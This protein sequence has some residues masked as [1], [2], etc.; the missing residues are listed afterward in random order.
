MD[1]GITLEQLSLYLILFADDMVIISRT[2]EGLQLSLD[3]LQCYCE[4]WNLSVN[5][6][7][8]KIMVFRKDG[9]LSYNEHW[10]YNG[11]ELEIVN[12]FNYLGLVF[13]PGGSFMQATKTLSGKALRA[14]CSL[15][16]ITRNMEVPLNIMLN[17]FDSFV[18]SILCYASEIWG[19]MS[20]EMIERVQRKFCKWMLNV[21][22][23]TNNLAILS[24]LG[25]LPLCIERKV[26]IVKYWFKLFSNDNGNII[27]RVVYNQLV[28]DID[29]GITNWAYKVKR[30]LESSRFPEVWMFPGSVDTKTFI[31]V[32]RKRLID[33]H[34]SNWREEMEA[35]SS[36]SLFRHFKQTYELAPYLT[37]VLNRTYR[38]I[39]AKLRLS[40]HPLL[41]ETGCYTGIPRAERICGHCDSRDIEDEYHFVLICSK[42]GALRNTYIPRYFIRNPSVHKF[43]ELLNSSNTRTLNNLAIFTIKAL[44][45][46]L[47]TENEV[48][49]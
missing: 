7:K 27:L 5:S 32:L 26:K 11:I 18:C 21:K 15:L 29:K 9:R 36:L 14:M 40:S 47:E 38:N 25:R 22:R 30:L 3:R 28:D 10:F 4:T 44:K 33:V 49:Q 34:I 35:C 8:T 48:F 23:S 24:E 45:L 20:A 2:P 6:D 37:K 43:I 39:I 41:I 12:Q 16:S 13:T 46:R 17:L 1:A 42:Y 19:F 31:P